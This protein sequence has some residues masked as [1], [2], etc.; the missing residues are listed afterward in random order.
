MNALVEDQLVRLRRALDSDD[1]EAWLAPHRDGHRFY[2]GRYTG[3]TPKDDLR[4]RYTRLGAPRAGRRSAATTPSAARLQA[5]G[6][7]WTSSAR[8]GRSCRGRWA[9]SSC[10]AR[11]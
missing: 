9:P 5:D 10:A 8:T 2:F 1:A 11:T 3:Q 6:R 4:G 7:A